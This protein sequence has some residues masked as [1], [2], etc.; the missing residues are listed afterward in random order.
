MRFSTACILWSITTG[1]STGV[2]F[3]STILRACRRLG[4]GK[5]KGQAKSASYLN[6]TPL[7]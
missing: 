5:K 6:D 4:A 3:F 2:Q 7:E 1:V